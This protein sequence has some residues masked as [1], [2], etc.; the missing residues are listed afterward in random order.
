[1]RAVLGAA[2]T[3][4]GRKPGSDSG[5]AA[6]CRLSGAIARSRRPAWWGSRAEFG[7]KPEGSARLRPKLGVGA[8]P[9]SP[10]H[11]VGRASASVHP[12]Q[13][14]VGC[15]RRPASQR[16]LPA[17][18][19]GPEGVVRRTRWGAPRGRRPLELSDL[20]SGGVKALTGKE[21]GAAGRPRSRHPTD[22]SRTGIPVATGGWNTDAS[23]LASACFE[24][25]AR[26]N[27]TP[28]RL[29]EGEHAAHALRLIG[30]FT[31][32]RATEL[33]RLL[34]PG[35]RHSRKYAE[36]HLRKLLALRMV[37]ARRLP[38]AGAGTAFVLATRGAQFLNDWNAGQVGYEYRAGTDWGSSTNG[39]WEPPRSWRHDLIAT[40]VLACL[41]ERLE[42]GVFP[43]PMLRHWVPQAEKHPDGL[44]V[45]G[46]Q[47]SIW[48]EVE[49]ARKSGRNIEQL[50]RALA[51]ASLRRPCSSFH[52]VLGGVPIAR[53]MVAINAEARDE[54]GRRLNHLTRV[55]SALSK[56]TFS[57]HTQFTLLVAWVTLRGV[58][59][60]EVRIE[61]RVFDADTGRF[62]QAVTNA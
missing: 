29:D 52:E 56:Q 30:R 33:G 62:L 16:H 24:L 47:V 44:L 57:R 40:G 49:N 2:E 42:W 45:V 41:R 35:Q 18:R 28:P 12:L 21:D 31:W 4:P 27:K 61:E 14:V 58:G 13:R 26:M 10:P 11:V 3:A 5:Q 54:R 9:R 22:V 38:G 43:E 15:H 25:Y 17:P 1:M 8:T 51:R 48:L 59:V 20:W 6:G 34:H 7:R 55:E 19:S 46:N 60:D 32:L 39:I 50:V 53:G 23:I 36:K 37:V